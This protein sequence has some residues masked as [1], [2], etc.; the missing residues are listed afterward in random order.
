MIT[1]VRQQARRRWAL[2]LLLIPFLALLWPGLYNFDQPELAGVPFFY[3]FQ[4]AMVLL[5]AGL[6]AVVYWL[7]ADE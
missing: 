4:G 7:G 3:W 6:T 1:R 5:T 2:C